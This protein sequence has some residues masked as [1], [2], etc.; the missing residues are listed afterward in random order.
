MCS[1]E[2]PVTIVHQVNKYRRHC[3]CRGGD[4]NSRKP[5]LAAWKMVTKPKTKGGHGVINLRLQNEIQLMKNLHKFFNKEDLPRV[6]L[7]WTKYYTNGRVPGHT[8]KGSF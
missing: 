3:L 5:P 2:V 6:N 1:I 4:I 7:I 8:M